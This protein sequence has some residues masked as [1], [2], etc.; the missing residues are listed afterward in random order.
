MLAP[1]EIDEEATAL[2]KKDRDGSGLGA[3]EYRERFGILFE[4]G[5]K[6][7]LQREVSVGRTPEPHIRA[8]MYHRA[9]NN[10]QE[11]LNGKMTGYTT[12]V[13]TQSDPTIESKKSWFAVRGDMFGGQ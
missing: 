2:L 5:L 13:R 9:Y 1:W 11:W 7:R 12:P 3:V 8:G 10:R 4:A 6:K